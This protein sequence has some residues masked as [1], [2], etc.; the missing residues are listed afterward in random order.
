MPQDSSGQEYEQVDIPGGKVRVTY[1][2]HGW[3]DSPSVRIQIQDESGHLRQGPEIPLSVIGDV[4][5]SV[6]KLLSGRQTGA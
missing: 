2:P 4:V 6:V 3:A 5:G 1:I